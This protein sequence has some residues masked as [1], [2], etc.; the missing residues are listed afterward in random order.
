[1]KT[2]PLLTAVA[3]VV[4]LGAGSARAQPSTNWGP[5]V[6]GVRLSISST[7]R[8][9]TIVDAGFER[10]SS[11]PDLR[12]YRLCLGFLRCLVRNGST[13]TIDMGG[14]FG[15]SVQRFYSAFLTNSAGQTFNLAPRYPMMIADGHPAILVAPGQSR[16]YNASIYLPDSIPSGEYTLGVIMRFGPPAKPLPSPLPP[17]PP[18]VVSWDLPANPLK[19]RILAKD[20]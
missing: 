6:H 2:V 10:S 5:E 17:K 3:V 9:A 13:N 14:G 16:Q 11:S 20:P 4:T 19:I 18:P 15:Y 1:M 8:D 12:G 7:N